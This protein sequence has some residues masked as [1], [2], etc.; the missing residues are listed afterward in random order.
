MFISFNSIPHWPFVPFLVW[1]PQLSYSHANRH[2]VQ[3][4][5]A[6]N[7]MEER[8]GEGIINLLSKWQISMSN[9]KTC[10]KYK[11]TLVM[12]KKFP[13]DIIITFI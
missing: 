12:G 6:N 5:I 4:T 10:F 9:K 3:A 11:I 2:R 7:A 13:I 1:V 8:G